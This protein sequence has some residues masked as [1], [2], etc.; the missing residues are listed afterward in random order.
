[1][2]IASVSGFIS[3]L[4]L[5]VALGAGCDKDKSSNN[6][7]DGN[8]LLGV[9]GGGGGDDDLGDNDVF[10]DDEDN[11]LEE[12]EAWKPAER[13]KLPKRAKASEKCKTVGKGKD[14]K[15]E[16]G[17]VDPKP[18][19]SAS[20]GVYAIMGDFR[21][22]M[23]P[24]QV[25]KVL[26]QDIETEF[27]KRQSAAKGATSQDANRRWRQE[28]LASLKSDHTK[29]T[30][31]SKHRWGVS[32][33]QYEYQDDNN[34]EMLFIRTGTGLRKFFFFKDDELWKVLYAY[35]TD[36]W[37]GKSYDDIVKEK[38]KKWFGPSP[39]SKVKQDPETAAP[40]VRYNEWT[41]MDKEKVRSFDLT[42]VHGVIGLTV[43]DG[44]AESRIGERLPDGRREDDYSD[45]VGDVLG[46]SD[47]CYDKNGDISE[48]S[49]KEASGVE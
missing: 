12:G 49:E 39:Q 40:L 21:W 7:D 14:K 44:N 28:Q 43:V 48:C 34:E 9:G 32:L 3:V 4:A 8:N 15:K 2:Q 33:I 35:S 24:P 22:G 41:S 1:M 36:V 30:K 47:V 38:F 31:A 19:V 17:M 13:K 25:Y 11:A 18:E 29:F 42:A 20:H 6:P 46:G 26:A 23:T 37:P 45:V 16:C 10:G 5:S 27:A